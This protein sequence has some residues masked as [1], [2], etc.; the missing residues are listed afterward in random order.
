[1]GLSVSRLIF[2]MFFGLLGVDDDLSQ[3]HEVIANQVIITSE[4]GQL[5][6][7][8]AHEGI[9]QQSLTSGEK[10][11]EIEAKGVT[12]FVQTTKR[13]LGFSGQLQRWAVFSL[14]TSEHISQW[15]VTPRMIM[16]IGTQNVYGFQSHVGRWK[17][18]DWGAGETIQG[19]KVQGYV[20]V[21]W[22]NRRV[23]GFSAKTGGFF[24]QDVSAIPSGNP[25]EGNEHI[26]VFKGKDGQFVFRSGLAIWA[27]LP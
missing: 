10:I 2:C 3:A 20:G 26:V 9:T 17:Q 16:V 1:M 27:R 6:G 22:T 15:T 19:T 11:V 7:I 23:L 8:T 5:F 13:L 25:I 21:V 4:R 24:S 18:E 14:P 12:G